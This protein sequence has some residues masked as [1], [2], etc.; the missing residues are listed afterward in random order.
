MNLHT[1]CPQAGNTLKPA[2]P[3]VPGRDRTP[4]GLDQRGSW[5]PPMGAD[6]TTTH[7]SEFSCPTNPARL[8][9]ARLGHVMW[10][11]TRQSAGVLRHAHF[12][13]PGSNISCSM[14]ARLERLRRNRKARRGEARR[15][16]ARRRH[17]DDVCTMPLA[18]VPQRRGQPCN[19]MSSLWRST[20][21]GSFPRCAAVATPQSSPVRPPPP[22]QMVTFDFLFSS[23]LSQKPVLMLSVEQNE[24]CVTKSQ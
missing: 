4:R 3:S 2:K 19:V 16:L 1:P 7:A 15:G 8:G 10:H 14:P 13:L 17:A 23:T 22:P 6:K 9:S 21:L 24:A 11:A 18:V 20:P 5:S 12:S